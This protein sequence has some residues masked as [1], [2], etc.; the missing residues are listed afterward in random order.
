MKIALIAPH[1][2][3][4]EEI[5][6]RVIFSPG[7]LSLNLAQALA[8][9]GH[10][11]TLFTPGPV[12]VKPPVK[13]FQADLSLFQ[14]EL[15]QRGYGYL[16]LLK[17]HPLVYISLAR[18]VQAEIIAQAYELA[19]QGQFDL[20][21]VWCNEEELALINARFCH[22][23]VVF[24]HHEPFNFLAK[25]RSIF[26]KY[27]HLNW[28]SLSLSQRQTLAQSKQKVNWVGN[29]YHGL[30]QQLYQFN[31]QPA[32][33]WLYFG[34]IIQP[35]G[36]HLA[37]E[38]ALKAGKK[39]K[40]AGKH[41]AD[42]KKDRYW[43]KK[44]KPLLAKHPQQLEYLGFVKSQQAKQKLL[45]AAQVLLMPSTWQEPFGLVM[46]EA[47]ACGTPV[48]GF[49]Q[50]A[51]PE[52][53]QE[54]SPKLVVKYLQPAQAGAKQSFKNQLNVANLIKAAYQAESFSREKCR[55][56]FETNFSLEKMAQGYEQ[57]YAKLIK[58]D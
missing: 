45:G 23:P 1:I 6:P 29:V 56:Y 18:Q 41:Y 7:H 19:N 17:K 16:K 51:I 50:G 4:H 8:G 25:Y 58:V 53:L 9:L 47:L 11:L 34:R 24:S 14:A 36:V 44:I 3:M 12:A 39:L 22:K 10:E 54:L 55:S 49:D 21:H 31:H 40:L 2:F 27:Q 30:D 48:V 52:V 57:V 28:V 33:Y 15:K 5:L 26:D 13:N 43:Q 46:I 32:D 42:H 35:K 37:I 38:A 20:V